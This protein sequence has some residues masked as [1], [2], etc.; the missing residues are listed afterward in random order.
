MNQLEAYFADDFKKDWVELTEVQNLY[1]GALKTILDNY[2][3]QRKGWPY[4]LGDSEE[5]KG[6][7]SISTQSMILSTILHASGLIKDSEFHYNKKNII[8]SIYTDANVKYGKKAFNDTLLDIVKNFDDLITNENRQ[9]F[10]SDTYGD[11]DPLSLNWIQLILKNTTRSQPLRNVDKIIAKRSLEIKNNITSPRNIITKEKAVTNDSV[12]LAIKSLHFIKNANE[13]VRDATFKEYFE[14]KLHLNL[15]YFNIPDA[16]FDP[17][18]VAF[19][20]EGALL[21]TENCVSD[22][23]IERAFSILEESQKTTKQ[24]RPVNPVYATNGGLTFL[25]LSIEVANS[26]LRSCMLLNNITKGE[27]YFSKHAQMFKS[28]F[29]WL[30]A[31][32]L[33]I[34]KDNATYLGWGSEHVGAPDTIHLWQTSEIVNF[35]IN[36]AVLLE[37][38]IADKS[39]AASGLKSARCND[40]KLAPT[41]DDE[42]RLRFWDCDIIANFEPLQS[43]DSKYQIYVKLR[44]TFISPRLSTGDDFSKVDPEYSLLLYGPPGT[45]KTSLAKNIAKTLGWKL[46]TVTPS[47]FLAGGSSEVESRAKSIFNCL[48]FQKNSVILFDEIDQFLLDRA[49]KA[50][51]TQ[52]GIFQFMTPGMLPKLNDLR[53]KANN[54]FVIATNYE[55]RIDPAIKR[56]GRIDIQYPLLPPDEHTRK[57]IIMNFIDMNDIAEKTRTQTTKFKQRIEEFAG[58]LA[59]VKA[60]CTYNDLESSKDEIIEKATSLAS[61]KIDIDLAINGVTCQPSISL[62]HYYS[63]L[64]DI[65]VPWHEILFVAHLGNEKLP[66]KARI[67]TLKKGFLK[68]IN[69]DFPEEIKKGYR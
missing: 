64:G 58:K 4:S 41:A 34:Q 32:A 53:A 48:E 25:P 13:T 27:S 21:C 20:L 30:K 51:L 33:Q 46:I 26:I 62:S 14:T 16:R 55:E 15:S 24:W 61:G 35:L 8:T 22:E 49:S 28:Y 50:Y 38:R 31:Q 56:K 29:K 45:G 10:T 43:F 6:T 60:L 37:Q 36:Y 40:P 23:T 68:T 47:D 9:S 67:K 42:D 57:R 66:Y 69:A 3:M 19:A 12:F 2:D 63:R 18:E 44:N 17:A 54:I 39:L 65:Q 7:D 59:A 1:S 11:N 5:G 52:T